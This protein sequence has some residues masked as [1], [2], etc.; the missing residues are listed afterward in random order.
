MAVISSRGRWVNDDKL[1]LLQRI[2]WGWVKSAAHWH[3]W[4]ACGPVLRNPH[5]GNR[6]HW[7]GSWCWIPRIFLWL[8]HMFSEFDDDKMNKVHLSLDLLKLR[9]S[10]QISCQH[11]SRAI[12]GTFKYQKYRHN[13]SHLLYLHDTINNSPQLVY[14]IGSLTF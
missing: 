6:S 8:I 10:H 3:G 12:L 9:Y 5:A 11:H 7:C 2:A 13:T 4:G 14:L 1:E